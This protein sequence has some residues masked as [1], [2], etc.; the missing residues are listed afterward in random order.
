[1]RI[2]QMIRPLVGAIAL[3]VLA[4]GASAAAAAATINIA[5]DTAETSALFKKQYGMTF[6]CPDTV[7]IGKAFTCTYSKGGTTSS[8]VY[9]IH[10]QGQQVVP[11]DPAAAADALNIMFPLPFWIDV[12]VKAYN[13][14]SSMH[15]VTVSCPKSAS[16]AASVL[17]CT[18]TSN[19]GNHEATV[20]MRFKPMSPFG[21]A[22]VPVKQSQFNSALCAVS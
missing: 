18:L 13:K 6:D 4:V 17:S 12:S 19:D 11:V 21:F 1:M 7:T 3:I 10:K 14:P 5:S 15:G 22:L 20:K 2:P 16:S 9:I 8:A